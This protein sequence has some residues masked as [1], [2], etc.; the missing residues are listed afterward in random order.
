MSAALSHSNIYLQQNTMVLIFIWFINVVILIILRSADLNTSY[1]KLLMYP[2]GLQVLQGIN[3]NLQ[4]KA[5][6]VQRT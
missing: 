5:V 2:H 4:N 3:E 1:F 6:S